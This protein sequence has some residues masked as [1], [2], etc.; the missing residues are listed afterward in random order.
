MIGGDEDMD[1][2]ILERMMGPLEHLLR[3]AV[4]HGIEERMRCVANGK[5]GAGLIT[6]QLA[7]EGPMSCS[8]WPMTVP[9]STARIRDKA[10]E[11]GL[12]SSRCRV[13]DDDL[14]QMIL[15]PVSRPQELSQ[16]SGRGV[17]MDVVLTE[18]KQLG[19]ALEIR[20]PGNGTGFTIRLPFTLAITD[21]LLVH[22]GEDIYAVPTAAWMGWRVSRRRS[23][24]HLH[25]GEQG[26]SGTAARIHVRY[27]G[28]MLAS[29]RRQSAKV[30]AGCRCCWCAPAN[31]GSRSR[32]MA[33][34]AT[35][36][37]WSSRSVRS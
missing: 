25:A 9:V 5:C 18:V 4:S 3:N 31:T 36:R 20:Q 27:L 34:W 19:G 28:T 8:R 21:A 11:R 13:D 24:R 33:C 6:L 26:R 32:S 30:C 2:A 14:Y 10:M 17:G 15:Q 29:R 37:S 1:R 22:V 7:R 12:L 35:G 23:A 16:V